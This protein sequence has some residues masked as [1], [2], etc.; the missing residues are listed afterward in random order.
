MKKL[1]IAAAAAAMIGGAYADLAYDYTANVKTTV[2]KGGSL[3]TAKCELGMNSEGTFW[4]EDSA[5][6][7]ELGD[8]E[9][10]IYR[11]QSA[12]VGND[13]VYYRQYVGT[14]DR[15]GELVSGSLKDKSSASIYADCLGYTA[16]VTFSTDSKG[17]YIG[18]FNKNFD[19]LDNADKAI[20]AAY[21]NGLND[22]YN[23]KSAGQWCQTFTY[24]AGNLCYRA[25][26]SKK[27]TA[28]VVV[29][30]CCGE[31][32]IGEYTD[33]NKDGEN[34]TI[35]FK[36]I[37]RFG[38]TTLAKSTKIEVFG[39]V[40][41]DVASA[42]DSIDQFTIAGQG[43]WKDK[44]VKVDGEDVKGISNISGNIV[45]VLAAPTCETCCRNPVDAT[46][47]SCDEVEDSSLATAAYGT[48][49]IKFNKSASDL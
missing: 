3:Q 16:L 14:N 13:T 10:S 49:S 34:C 42:D 29:N 18:K 19:A 8:I 37:N 30:D 31:E 9:N 26:G 40:G 17:A 35:G 1:M 4:Y 46:A 23:R 12:K 38:A 39:Y 2:G 7:A 32:F 11:I 48:W 15:D 47:W 44:L 27:F 25:A 45:G 20:I 41:D 28:R 6:I 21:F 5:I 36:F 24:K 33:K 22:K 43:T